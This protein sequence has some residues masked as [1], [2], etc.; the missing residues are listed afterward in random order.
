MGCGTSVESNSEQREAPSKQS[1]T[2]SGKYGCLTEQ[3]VQYLTAQ[4]D[5]HAKSQKD[6][7]MVDKNE[8]VALL[9]LP[10]SMLTT[11]IYALFDKDAD[12][13]MTKSEFLSVMGILHPKGD[14]GEKMK[15]AFKFWDVDNDGYIDKDELSLVVREALKA[16]SM[17]MSESQFRKLVDETFTL[18][19]AD[20]SG[21]ITTAEFQQL[22]RWY[23]NILSNMTLDVPA[24]IATEQSRRP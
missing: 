13:Q 1:P 22:V 4:F 17:L 14:A 3:E 10:P 23:P 18:A 11:R 5:H 15:L 24:M 20:N 7:G 16:G 8:F 12:G 2:D 6:D 19:D 21:K 9:G